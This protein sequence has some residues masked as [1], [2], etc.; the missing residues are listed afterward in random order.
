MLPTRAHRTQHTP[1]DVC[2]TSCALPS[3]ARTCDRPLGGLSFGRDVSGRRARVALARERVVAQVELVRLLRA[4][5]R[6]LERR[7]KRGKR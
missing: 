1:V 6:D 5:V 2:A 4:T 3:I 7:A